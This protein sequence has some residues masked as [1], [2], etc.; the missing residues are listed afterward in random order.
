ML[1]KE[2]LHN[3]TLIYLLAFFCVI[4]QTSV[5]LGTKYGFEIVDQYN[6]IYGKYYIYFIGFILM[7]GYALLWQ[8][9]LQKL[10]LSIASAFMA[11]TPLLVLLGSS[12]AFNEI[13]TLANIVGMVIVFTGLL[14]LILSR[15]EN[16]AI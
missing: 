4:Y 10:E 13:I 9:V 11:V 6:F 15:K 14:L 1:L 3:I 8:L 7:G 16:T 2:K 12:V 5:C